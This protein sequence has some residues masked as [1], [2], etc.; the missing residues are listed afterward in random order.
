MSEKSG[1]INPN[2]DSLIG[3]FVNIYNNRMSLSG[4]LSRTDYLNPSYILRFE[5]RDGYYIFRTEEIEYITYENSTMIK[6]KE[7]N[8]EKPE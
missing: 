1:V 5:N 2:I 3:S 8:Y 4:V 7:D 6:L